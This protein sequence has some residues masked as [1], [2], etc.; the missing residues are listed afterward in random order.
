MDG[1]RGSPPCR[2]SR[3]YGGSITNHHIPGRKSKKKKKSGIKSI[4]FRSD[5][6]SNQTN[7]NPYPFICIWVEQSF[8]SFIYLEFIHPA[9]TKVHQTIPSPLSFGLVMPT[10]MSCTAPRKRKWL[11]S[12]RSNSFWWLPLLP[13]TSHMCV[14]VDSSFGFFGATV[15][16]GQTGHGRK[17]SF[18]KPWE[19]QRQQSKRQQNAIYSNYLFR[20]W[21]CLFKKS[22]FDLFFF[23]QFVNRLRA[24]R[25]VSC[26]ST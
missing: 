16:Q 13:F 3:G 7:K 25:K 19:R 5:T 14:S 17:N 4:V 8:E 9:I 20:I 10:T 23:L 24:I 22:L 2:L 12:V 21:E 1:T 6:A 18:S 11:L 26:V 15:C